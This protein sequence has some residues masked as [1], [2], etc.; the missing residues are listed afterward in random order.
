MWEPLLYI[1]VIAFFHLWFAGFDLLS[2]A[3]AI[4]VELYSFNSWKIITDNLVILH[5]TVTLKLMCQI[6]I[7]LFYL[8]I[9]F[10]LVLKLKWCIYSFILFVFVVFIFYI[11][12][13]CGFK[14]CFTYTHWICRSQ[15][16]N[17]PQSSILLQGTDK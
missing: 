11:L 17:A 4:V 16:N 10:L 5:W 15:A 13:I 14:D 6:T 8:V 12:L 3:S 2:G 1:W 7:L 9:I